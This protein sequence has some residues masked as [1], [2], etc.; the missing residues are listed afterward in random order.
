MQYKSE[1][2]MYADWL[3]DGVCLELAGIRR[4]VWAMVLAR[5]ATLCS[6]RYHSLW[7]VV[8]AV[9][10]HCAVFAAAYLEGYGREVVAHETQP[11]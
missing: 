7:I 5:M 4:I 3:S 10:L 6:K 1:N 9:E 2:C 11:R 8:D